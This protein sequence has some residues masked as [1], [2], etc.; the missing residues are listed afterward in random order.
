VLAAVTP[1]AGGVVFAAD[2]DGATYAFDA[3]DGKVL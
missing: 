3:T 2:M 1:T